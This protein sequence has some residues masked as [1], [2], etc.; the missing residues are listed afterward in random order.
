MFRLTRVH[1][2]DHQAKCPYLSSG[3]LGR[4]LPQFFSPSKRQQRNGCFSF[5]RNDHPIQDAIRLSALST[6]SKKSS[7]HEKGPSILQESAGKPRMEASVIGCT[8]AIGTIRKARKYFPKSIFQSSRFRARES[9]L[10]RMI[11]P[12]PA[13]RGGSL[14]TCS[15]FRIAKPCLTA[16]S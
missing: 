3:Q 7:T 12:V 8:C 16:N 9:S 2:V 13:A 14:S 5:S 4:R 10:A 1:S 11:V 6:R 15:Y